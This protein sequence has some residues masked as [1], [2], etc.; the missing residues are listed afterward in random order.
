MVRPSTKKED[1]TM[2][3]QQYNQADREVIAMVSNRKNQAGYLPAK[4][5]HYIPEER[6]GVVLDLDQRLEKLRNWLPVI[7][8]WAIALAGVIIGLCL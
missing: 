2:S 6:A 8:V 1:T 5:I 7:A 3:E 4:S